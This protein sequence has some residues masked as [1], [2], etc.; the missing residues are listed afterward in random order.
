[1]KLN[2]PKRKIFEMLREIIKNRKRLCCTNLAYK[3]YSV[4]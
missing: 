2:I 1:M 3:V 4:L